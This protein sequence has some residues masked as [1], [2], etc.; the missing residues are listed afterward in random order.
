[1]SDGCI[2]GAEQNSCGGF[3]LTDTPSDTLKQNVF[4]SVV[5]ETICKGR[6]K[7]EIASVI[8]FLQI[9]CCLL[10]NYLF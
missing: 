6:S 2:E 1:M 8:E 10:K 5:A 3:R 7:A 4:A 9:L